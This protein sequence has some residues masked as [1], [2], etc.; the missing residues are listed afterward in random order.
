[1][2]MSPSTLPT[3]EKEP[4]DKLEPLPP[5]QGLAVSLN[6]ERKAHEHK[7]NHTARGEVGQGAKGAKAKAKPKSKA[8]KPSSSRQ[9]DGHDAAVGPP[10]APS[11]APHVVD[12]LAKLIEGRAMSDA[13]TVGIKEHRTAITALFVGPFVLDSVLH[14]KAQHW[15]EV[16][17]EEFAIDLTMCIAD[18]PF[19]MDDDLECKGYWLKPDG[20][21]MKNG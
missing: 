1:M 13:A 11:V 7:Y 18:P 5:D 9:P 20:H 12:N 2:M 16:L 17:E 14:R 10:F 4:P 6:Y 21:S 15:K 8:T 19:Q 3:V